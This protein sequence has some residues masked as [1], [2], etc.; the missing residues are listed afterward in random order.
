MFKCDNLGNFGQKY[1][2]RFGAWEG[3][4]F[5]SSEEKEIVNEFR[6]DYNRKYGDDYIIV[7]A[8]IRY[9]NKEIKKESIYNMKENIITSLY[10]KIEKCKLI[11]DN[12]YYVAKIKKE[13]K[14]KKYV[15]AIFKFPDELIFGWSDEIYLDDE[16]IDGKCEYLIYKDSGKYK[17]LHYPTKEILLEANFIAVASEFDSYFYIRIRRNKPKFG[18]FY[19]NEKKYEELPLNSLLALRKEFKLVYSNYTGSTRLLTKYK[20]NLSHEYF[21]WSCPSCNKDWC[22]YI[23]HKVYSNQKFCLKC[24]LE[25]LYPF[26]L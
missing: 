19:A 14:K 15:K 20:I 4:N 25:K 3:I 6:P 9:Y 26:S 5:Y 7:E 23:Q 10:D 13:T 18:I 17:L 24:D 16:L 8:I 2:I 11:K 1:V 22:L 21:E 12:L